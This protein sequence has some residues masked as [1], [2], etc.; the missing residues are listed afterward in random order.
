MVM[1][2]AKN[3]CGAISLL[4][5]LVLPAKA[6]VV[7]TP[8]AVAIPANGSYQIDL[9]NDGIADFTLRSSVGMVWC[10]NGDGGYWKLTVQSSQGNGVVASDQNAAALASGVPVD[11]RQ[12]FTGGT[13]LMAYF[14]FGY[15]GSFGRGSWYNVS[16]RYLGLEF[17]ENGMAELHYGWA[18]L[19]DFAYIDKQGHL[20][21]GTML[22][23]FAYETT[24]GKTIMTGQ[25]SDGP[26]DLGRPHSSATGFG[27]SAEPSD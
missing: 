20:Q 10:Q 3:M 12:S 25:I 7:Y 4:A 23:G 11:V 5:A 22:T 16:D 14:A 15:C 9:N 18:E 2:F 17:Q 21:V 24:P 1:N 13:N 26:D 19:S 27:L 8:V 6:E